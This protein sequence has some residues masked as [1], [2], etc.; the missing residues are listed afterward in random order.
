VPVTST[1]HS[2]ALFIEKESGQGHKQGRNLETGAGAEAMQG[3]ASWLVP[4][5][6]LR[7]LPYRTQNHK[8]RLSSPTMLLALSHQSLIKKISYRVVYG[9]NVWRHFLN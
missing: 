7:L 2:T 6:S 3:A 8:P 4:H 5:G 1:Y 9:P